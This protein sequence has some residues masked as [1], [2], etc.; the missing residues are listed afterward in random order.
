M[1]VS[2]FNDWLSAT[3]ITDELTP[4]CSITCIK[5]LNVWLKWH[6]VDFLENPPLHAHFCHPSFTCTWLKALTCLLNSLVSTSAL[7]MNWPSALSDGKVWFSSV[8]SPFFL[9]PE[10][11]H[12]F[13]LGDLPEPWTEPEPFHLVVPDYVI[14]K[15]VHI[16]W[17][18]H[19]K[20]LALVV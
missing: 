17:V 5:L 19:H 20:S 12:Q 16:F 4:N 7:L 18:R 14:K 6:P 3:L 15:I 13:S 11:N 1:T 8:Q 10:P 2:V 9:N